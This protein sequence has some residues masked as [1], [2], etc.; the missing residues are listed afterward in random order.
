MR[1]KAKLAPEQI[2]ALQSIIAHIARL[3]G[4]SPK[5][6]SSTDAMVRN[7]SYSS[8][9]NYSAL[10]LG[11]GGGSAVHAPVIYLDPEHVRIAVRSGRGDAEGIACFAELLSEKIFLEHRIES[12][13]EDQIVFEIDLHMFK[14]ALQSVLELY[15]SRMQNSNHGSVALHNSSSAAS[16]EHA[17][18]AL[19]VVVMKLAKR[20]GLPCL[21]L[22]A[23]QNG[24]YG[25][26]DQNH[27]LPIKVM[28]SSEMQFHLPPQI[29]MP[30]VQLEFPPD[31]RVPIKVIL[32]RLKN[33]KAQLYVDGSMASGELVFR[34]EGEGSSIRTFYNKLIPRWEDCKATPPNSS[35]T[36]V[37][38][39]DSIHNGRCTV[40][41][42]SKK[43]YSCFQWQSSSG[44]TRHVKSAVLCMAENEMVVMHVLLN[45]EDLGFFTYYCPVHF[46]SGDAMDD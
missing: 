25:Q 37:S 38:Q 44:M 21:C 34:V 39:T 4:S 12:A 1:F 46:L 6:S 24:G 17:C 40:K 41:V 9:Q 33:L 27:A 7:Q 5:V 22:E 16:N 30:D 35:P 36:N 8:S 26:M 3:T 14:T 13:A 10:S 45:P 43:L 2:V 31:G 32:E 23:R 20:S 19:S 28:R 29:S 11:G 42:D 15:S 18:G